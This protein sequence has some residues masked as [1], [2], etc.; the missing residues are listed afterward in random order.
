[1]GSGEGGSNLPSLTREGSGVGS[2]EGVT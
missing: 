2:E 1:V